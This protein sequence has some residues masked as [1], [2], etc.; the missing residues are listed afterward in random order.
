MQ[1]NLSIDHEIKNTSVLTTQTDRGCEGHPSPVQ[2]KCV[3]TVEFQIG[4]KNDNPQRDKRFSG[5]IPHVCVLATGIKRRPSSFDLHKVGH[6][7]NDALTE[8]DPLKKG[9]LSPRDDKRSM[10]HPTSCC[11]SRFLVE[12]ELAKRQRFEVYLC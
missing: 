1:T 3:Q 5:T 8:R 11:P 7:D 2:S 6:F 9:A 10:G 4:L 12:E